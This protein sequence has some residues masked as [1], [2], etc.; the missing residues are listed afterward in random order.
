MGG[1]S[2]LGATEASV[3]GEPLPQSAQPA[4]VDMPDI[5]AGSALSNVPVAAPVPNMTPGSDA[6]SHPQQWS[7]RPLPSTMVL[8]GNR[9]VGGSIEDFAAVSSVP[10]PA[11]ANVFNASS[12]N[13]VSALVD[14]GWGAVEDCVMY[15]ID[16][17]VQITFELGAPCRIDEV[18]WKQWWATTSSRKTAYQ[19]DEAIVTLS[20]DGFVNDSREVGKVIDPGPHPS[21]GSPIDYRV[22]ADRQVA[23]A[24]RITIAPKA[25]TAVYLA[26]AFIYGKPVNENDVAVAPFTFT[27][28][29]TARINPKGDHVV[30]AATEEGDLIAVRADGRILW[31]QSFGT[32]LNDVH[33]VDINGD[34]I[35]EIALAR[36]DYNLSLLQSNGEEIWSRKLTYYR[37]NPYVNV[38]RSGDLNGDG[39]PEII[40]GGE[41]WR[42]YAFDAEGNELWNFEAVHPSRSGAVA[43]LDGDG[44][45]E[46]IC[47]THYYYLSVL[48]SDGTPRW[49]AHF[50]PICWDV[51][52]GSFDGDKTRGVVCGSGDGSIYYFAYDGTRRL[53]FNT[54]DEVRDVAAA[55]L[56]GDGKDEILGASFSTNVYC[57]GPDAKQKWYVPLGAPVG[58]LV[59]VSTAGGV[60]VVA[61]TTD[62]HIAT[63]NGDGKLIAYEGIGSAPAAMTVLDK[64]VVVAT[65]DGRMIRMDAL[66]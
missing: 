21:W 24:V 8:S 16:D 38:V 11:E 52:T 1:L 54:G 26:E 23:S 57:F 47:G 41:N 53:A 46:V 5:D 60:V 42:F 30:L 10:E 51:D 56:D 50:G 48:N 20:N 25:G 39:T 35:D 3:D 33:A 31:S 9:G 55:D 17:T 18:S 7:F 36:A 27:R 40:C 45:A 22:M 14:G 65:E 58:H 44:T 4:S 66:P 2:L 19:L 15:K 29:C 34:G 43:D 12:P 6:P 62:G 59:T 64:T 61:G 37:K 49:R 13:S 32:K 63:L 28:L